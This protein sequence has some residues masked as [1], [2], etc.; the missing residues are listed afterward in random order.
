MKT[1]WLGSLLALEIGFSKKKS[2][3]FE[4]CI[5]FVSSC[6]DV[7]FMVKNKV[8]LPHVR[9]QFDVDFHWTVCQPFLGIVLSAGA[10]SDLFSSLKKRCLLGQQHPAVSFYFT[11]LC[12][13]PQ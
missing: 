2:E 12:F 9:N 5:V 3:Y 8:S 7:K 6:R 10:S 13:S 11:S 1:K 4:L